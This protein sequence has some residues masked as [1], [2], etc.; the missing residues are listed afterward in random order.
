MK[1]KLISSLVV[2]ILTFS[3]LTM[4]AQNG[5][6]R[7]TVLDAEYGDPLIGAYVEK[8]GSGSGTITD[9]D[10][11]FELKLSPGSHVIT[12]QYEGYE[13]VKKTVEVEID[14]ITLVE[15]SLGESQE[16]LDE[17]VVKAKR[18][19]NTAN[20]L[21]V[22]KQKSAVVFD[23]I[24]AEQMSK[25]AESNAAG[26][27]TRV[28]GVSVEGG[29]YVYVRGLGDRYSKTVLNGSEVPSLDPERNS[30]QMD[31]FPSNIIDNLQV[32]KSFSPE[33]P[34]D[35]SGGLINIETKEFPS[36]FF[37]NFSAST[38]FNTQSTLNKNFLSYQGSKTDWLGFDNGFR[39]MPEA[40]K[41][42]TI[43]YLH[44][45]N[46]TLQ[47]QGQSFNNIMTTQTKQSGINQNYSFSIGDQKSIKERPFGYYLGLSY[48]K[49][50]SY[51]D[52]GEV[53][54][55]NAVSRSLLNPQFL[56]ND[57]QGS[58]QVTTGI[59][60]NIHYKMNRNNKI[61]LTIMRNQSGN[62]VAR[63]LEGQWAEDGS[64]SEDHIFVSQS[65]QYLGRTMNNALLKGQHILNDKKHEVNWSS[66]TTLSNQDEPDL[67]FVAYDYVVDE[68]GNK[69]YRIQKNAYD[70]PARYYREMKELNWHSKLEYKI[71]FA[72]RIDDKS[73]FK[74]GI[75]YLLKNRTFDEKRI[76]YFETDHFDGNLVDFFSP[77]NMDIT[78]YPANN[79]S[80]FIIPF[81]GDD[82]INS[83]TG[84]QNLIAGFAQV[85]VPLFI[86]N[87]RFNGGLRVESTDI[88]VSS[89]D[90]RQ[91]K[92]QLQ[93]IDL[94]PALNFV[95]K[96][97]KDEIL[98]NL[99][100]AYSRTV[101]RPTFRELAPFSS[102][103]FT[104][105]FVLVGNPELV[106]SRIQN[107]DFRY[108]IFPKHGEYFSASAFYKTFE[109]PIEKTSN[110]IASNTEITFTNVGDANLLGIEMELNK[111]LGF[112][113]RSLEDFKLGW[114]GSLIRSEVKIDSLEY[115]V[116]SEIDN[117]ARKTRPMYS[118]SPY[119]LNTYLSYS[120]DSI[121]LDINLSY[122]VF[123]KRLALV[124][125]GELPDV[126]EMPRP[127]LD[128]SIFQQVNEKIKLSFTAKNLLNPATRFVHSYAG[129]DY[130]YSSMKQGLSFGFGLK[131]AI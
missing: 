108:E 49:S 128:F 39:D 60:G 125:Q 23:G 109:N 82:L 70:L 119:I 112:I 121:G 92:G 114:N 33:L 123:G 81:E 53:G 25:Q 47:Q 55:Y 43:P 120:N 22:M 91:Q 1:S 27:L 110:P 10:G 130:T 126:Y 79:A 11:T 65:L 118:Q 56:L 58:E 115:S 93:N 24:A 2:F 4:F 19:T 20:A 51:Y 83:Y 100:V 68:G 95:Y 104:G 74:L 64:V 117:N 62:S 102:F 75:S 18:V 29:K 32:F 35:F 111:D 72:T 78:P 122:N 116:R 94:L 5:T 113:H 96:M 59:F 77:A 106:R 73:A 26:A 14:K 52:N 42:H 66:S 46:A 31:L 88:S 12:F 63:I 30:V 7:G 57:Q 28:T 67:R 13:L 34:G 36:D 21:I 9:M 97:E 129:Q 131:Y 84:R 45:D 41:D 86:P 37:V 38:G 17:A 40:A 69:R 101:A 44:Q 8:A 6:V 124:S 76:S 16:V 71:P 99:R 107:F 87:L 85:D 3:S 61:G 98:S 50:F 89:K 54:R 48:R 127:S 15:V 80:T 103:F 90:V 105:D